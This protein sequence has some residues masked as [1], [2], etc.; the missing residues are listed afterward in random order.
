MYLGGLGTPEVG[1]G[2]RR[3]RVAPLEQLTACVGNEDK[4]YSLSCTPRMG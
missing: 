3:L 1:V 2:F 4:R